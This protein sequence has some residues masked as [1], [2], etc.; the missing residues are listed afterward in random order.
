MRTEVRL[1]SILETTITLPA[2]LMTT[3]T[4]D[5]MLISTELMHI[6]FD[7]MGQPLL[8]E[9]SEYLLEEYV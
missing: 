9:N 8:G 7:E 5:L 3:V 2:Y 6:I 1:P 4:V